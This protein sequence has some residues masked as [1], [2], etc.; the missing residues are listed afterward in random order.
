MS[1]SDILLKLLREEMMALRRSSDNLKYSL[2]KAQTIELQPTMSEEEYE[3]LDSFLSRFMRM[4]E[5]LVNQ[6]LRTTLQVI[7]EGK[8]TWLDNMNQAEKLGFISSRQDMNAVREL[9]NMVAHEYLN[10]EWMLIYQRL[11][12]KSPILFTSLDMIQKEI[13]KR[14]ILGADS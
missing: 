13:K 8:D 4:Y 12:E 14:G 10:E 11:I 9:R 6:V 3:V 2:R 5:V 1:N 7:A